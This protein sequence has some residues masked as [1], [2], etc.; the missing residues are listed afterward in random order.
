LRITIDARMI[1]HT[2]IG[3]Y[4]RNIVTNLAEIKSPHQYSVLVNERSEYLGQSANLKFYTTVSPVPIYSIKEQLQLVSDIRRLKPELVHYPSFN[5]PR[6]CL[7]PAVVNI[8]DLTY[9]VQPEACPHYAA[10]LYAR[11]MFSMVSR[12]AARIITGSEYTK[13]EI[14]ERLG[15]SPAKVTVIYNGVDSSFSA[16]DAGS[17]AQKA[18]LSRYGIKGDYIFFIG[19]H[20]VNKNLKRLLEAF[21]NLKSRDCQLILAGKTDP[22]RRP[23][24][25]LVVTLGLTDRA[26]F[27]GAVSEADLVHLYSAAK[28][29]VFPSLQ[30]GF[31][32]P[33]LEA[34][35]CGTPVA[36]ST[37]TSLPE[38]VGD[39]AVTF[40]PEDTDAIT[41]AMERVLASKDLRDELR[42]RG[43]ERVK[44]FSWRTAAEL[45]LKVYNDARSAELS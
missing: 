27:I 16:S 42:E 18:A 30:E 25:D 13:K 43:F 45:T 40:D 6:L 11:Y 9:L 32:L 34:M 29:F 33:P 35:A 10:R 4:I 28:L 37:A 12:K 26:R 41:A 8:H 23:L 17:V 1:N 3:R 31:G 24:Y 14:V 2:G 15:V 21:S 39:A 36:S 38:V 5:V 20:G 44:K 19:N 7:T 22:K